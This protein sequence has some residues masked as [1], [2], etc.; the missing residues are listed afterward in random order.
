MDSFNVCFGFCCLTQWGEWIWTIFKVSICFLFVSICV[1]L[2]VC[3]GSRWCAGCF[4]FLSVILCTSLC[5]YIS[6]YT[7]NLLCWLLLSVWFPS[8]K[9]GM[10][11]RLQIQITLYLQ[12]NL[13]IA[14]SEPGFDHKSTNSGLSNAIL[15]NLL[16]YIEIPAIETICTLLTCRFLK[17]VIHCIRSIL[18]QGF[19]KIMVEALSGGW[20]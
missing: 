2:C 8:C 17:S 3:Q 7:V 13:M 20:N 16:F 10:G 4:T 9:R 11:D 19:W 1:K 6:L 18:G 15:S 12:S 5:A 14:L